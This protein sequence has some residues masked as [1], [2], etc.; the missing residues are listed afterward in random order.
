V[1]RRPRPVFALVYDRL[2][3]AAERRFMGEVRARLAGPARGRVLELGA[4]PGLTFAHYGPGAREV[5]AVEPDPHMLRRAAPRARACGGRVTLLQ[6][7][8]ERLPLPDGHV[9]TVLACL[10]L[11]SVE[12]PAAALAEARRVLRPGGTLRLW[13]HVRSASPA[14]AAAQRLVTP[15]WRRVAGGCHPAR[16]TLAA[17]EAAGFQLEQVS[18]QAVGPAGPW[19]SA[20]VRPHVFAVARRP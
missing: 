9:D 13:E 19:P 14:G 17:V 1:T 16:D 15:L 10:V 5:I 3:A 12:D 6:A 2:A 20:P 18:P 7:P 4:G 11:C 8:A